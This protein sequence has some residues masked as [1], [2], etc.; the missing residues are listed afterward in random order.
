MGHV[1]DGAIVKP[2][3]RTWIAAAAVLTLGALA[4]THASAATA[5]RQTRGISASATVLVPVS[6]SLTQNLSSGAVKTHGSSPTGQV[7]VPATYPPSPAPTYINADAQNGSNAQAPN[8]AQVL[9]T[10]SPGQA[11]T[12]NFQNWTQ[13]GG[14]AGSTA[15]AA[16][17]TYYLPGSPPNS[18]QGVFNAQGKAT[19]YIGSTITVQRSDSATTVV[20]KPNFTVTYN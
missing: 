14:V 11:F 19:V 15:S 6:I 3:L 2:R 16:T 8:A 10:G 17:N 9:L 7:I 12:L 13:V 1:G 18:P 4:V 5:G 20:L